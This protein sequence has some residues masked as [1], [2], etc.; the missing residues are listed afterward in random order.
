MEFTTTR[1]TFLE[2][3]ATAAGGADHRNTMPTLGC[4]LLDG[5]G[6]RL[7]IVGTDLEMELTTHAPIA[8]TGRVLVPAKKLVDVVRSLPA[9]AEITAYTSD[10]RLLLRAGRSRF[11]L[12]T[13]PAD[14][15]PAFDYGQ[16][17]APVS[18]DPA[19]LGAGLAATS[20]AMAVQDVRYYLNGMLVAAERGELVLVASDGHRLA[21]F[22]ALCPAEI[23]PCIVPRRTVLE[24]MRAIKGA[25]SVALSVGRPGADSAWNTLVLD[26]PEMRIG[27]KLLE[28][29]FPDW[30]RVWPRSIERTVTVDRAALASALRQAAVLTNEKYKSVAVAFEKEAIRIRAQDPDHDEAE[31]DVEADLEGEGFET[32]F[33]AV[34]LEDALARLTGDAVTLGFPDAR[35]ACLVQDPDDGRQGH[36]VMP[37]RL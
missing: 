23:P 17:A 14:N 26:L 11:T 3:L 18:V 33:N 37:M 30:Q 20:Y 35:D 4:V 1:D 8:A 21:K 28:G 13:L 7:R 2:P 36:I 29:K 9:D 10:D 25:A 32:G 15:F 12:A 27:A 24:I 22:T 19:V 5:Q 6:E 16:T 31:V 34:Y